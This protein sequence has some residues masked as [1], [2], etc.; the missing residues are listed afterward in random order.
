MN[1][2][3]SRLARGLAVA[4]WAEMLKFRRSRAPWISALGIAIVPLAGGLFMLIL[5][6]P[7]FAQRL[8]IITT[9]AQL[10]IRAAD[11]PS[12]FGFLAQAMSGGGLF[13]F[14]LLVIW[15]FGREFSDRTA[16]DLLA[17]P[18][19]RS[20]IVL[21]KFI[22]A[23]GWSALL[24]V[25]AFLLSLGAGLAIGM[26]GW[27]A[28]LALSAAGAQAQAAILTILLVSPF[29]WV[30]SAGRGYLPPI[31]VMLL[32]VILGQVFTTIGWGPYYPWAVPALASGA[33]GAAGVSSLGVVSYVLMAL[34]VLVGIGGTLAWWRFAD[35]T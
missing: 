18:T 8:G 6:Y 34:A 3:A 23:A 9:K 7:Q 29:A 35:Q 30:A 1:G 15:V 32:V 13:L 5:K 28:E 10:L 33:A 31:G 21:A 14:G 17:L 4:L 24:A 19:A 25:W 22:V 11:W 26:P 2:L 16:K 27:S 12:Y 20:A